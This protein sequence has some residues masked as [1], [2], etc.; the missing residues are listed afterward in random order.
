MD[1]HNNHNDAD[2]LN[3]DNVLDLDKMEAFLERTEVPDGGNRTACKIFF[4]DFLN[5]A[6]KENGVGILH[7][8][9]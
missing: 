4:K 2:L 7:W 9:W 3:L 8:R 1:V 5:E 6:C